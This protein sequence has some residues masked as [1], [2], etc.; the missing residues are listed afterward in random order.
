MKAL[1]LVLVV[2]ACG[3]KGAPPEPSA[4]PVPVQIDWPDA[5]TTTTRTTSP[6]PSPSK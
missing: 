3:P 5:S 2:G 1:L 4:R 6:S